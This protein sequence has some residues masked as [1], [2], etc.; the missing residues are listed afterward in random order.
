MCPPIALPN[1]I[2][3]R[4]GSVSKTVDFPDASPATQAWEA[5]GACFGRRNTHPPHFCPSPPTAS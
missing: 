5:G 1:V 2:R 4:V 3:Y